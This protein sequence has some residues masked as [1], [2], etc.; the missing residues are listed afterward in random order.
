MDDIEDE[1]CGEET[2]AGGAAAGEDDVAGLLAAEGCSGGE[3]LL[4]DVLVADGRAEH[5]YFAALERGFEAHVGH[6][7]GDYGRVGE[8][9][10]GLE[11]TGGEQEDGVS[12]D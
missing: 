4:E 3:H 12:V 2:V 10:E 6:G 7:G 11:V 8:E 9:V 1:E 5:F